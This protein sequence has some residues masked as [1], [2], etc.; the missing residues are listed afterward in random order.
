MSPEE[1]IGHVRRYCEWAESKAHD[2]DAVYQLL[3]PLKQGAPA[4]QTSNTFPPERTFPG[5]SLDVP[6]AAT[7]QFADFPFQCYHVVFWPPDTGWPYEA[8]PEGKFTENIHEDFAHIHAELRHGLQAMERDGLT[9]ALQY[10]RDSYFFHW[11]P[12]ASAAIWAI[13]QHR[14]RIKNFELGASPNGGPAAPV[15][16]SEATEE[17]PSVS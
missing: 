8:H 6:W 5:L 10:W 11:G 3:L 14:E 13:E 4:L 16:N 1:F 17:P 7:K 15:G 2:I 12:H 9:Q